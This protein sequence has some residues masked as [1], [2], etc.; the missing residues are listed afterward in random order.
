MIFGRQPVVI[1]TAIRAVLLAAVGFGL[2]W[3][4][5]QIAVFMLAVEA[6]LAV[7]VAPAVTPTA[8][9]ILS[10]GTTVTVQTPKG[11]PDKSVT[12]DRELV[13]KEGTSVPA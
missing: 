3:E 11:Q 7:I 6:I 9:P 10:Q 13:Q 2:S 8:S 4:P 12:L 1:S 5:E